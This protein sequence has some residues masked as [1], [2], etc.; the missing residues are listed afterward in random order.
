[1]KL[2]SASSVAITSSPLP[3]TK[4]ATA[5]LTDPMCIVPFWH[6]SQPLPMGFSAVLQAG[7][8]AGGPVGSGE[9]GRVRGGASQHAAARRSP[10]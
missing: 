7:G 9:V 8:R 3:A 2:G 6:T 4:S 10:A 1:M 5:P